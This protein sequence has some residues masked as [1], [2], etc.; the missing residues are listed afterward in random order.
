MTST[1]LRALLRPEGRL[2][3][4][5]LARVEGFRAVEAAV[6]A[7]AKILGVVAT[8]EAE[9]RARAG[10]SGLPGVPVEAV[11]RPP[12]GLFET[13]TPQGV[14]ALARRPRRSLTAALEG[15]ATTVV[16]L[17]AVRDPGNVGTILRTAAAAGVGAAVALKG[18]ADPWG[19]KA[20]R[21]SVGAAWSLPVAADVPPE[22]A[23]AALAAAGFSIALADPRGG[24]AL[25]DWRPLG[26][27]GLVLGGEAE[28][29]SHA[30]P[31]A[32]R[33]RIPMA[34]AAESLNVAAAAAILIWHAVSVR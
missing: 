12:E 17:D 28:G 27:W 20:V 29:P 13:E 8:R 22:E 11:A 33:V 26:R 18:T 2:R 21:A 23:E 34:R 30:W 19:A 31:G 10:V 25:A 6:A 9:A 16:L 14:V 3:R 1:T 4:D 32:A 7:G 24:V 5:G 15:G